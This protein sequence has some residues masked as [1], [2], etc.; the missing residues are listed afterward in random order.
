MSKWTTR[1]FFL[2]LCTAGVVCGQSA[3]PTSLMERIGDTG[4]VRVNAES[5]KTL[6]AKQRELAYWLT[7][8]SIA[9]DPII[10]G[11]FSRTAAITMN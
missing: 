6:D 10:Y 8:A 4:F 9:I 11:Q 5:F 3:A 7:Q 2:F 1:L